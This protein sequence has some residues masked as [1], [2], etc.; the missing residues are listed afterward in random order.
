MNKENKERLFRDFPRLFRAP[1]CSEDISIV[2]DW[3]FECGDGWYELIYQLCSDIEDAAADAGV[4]KESTEWPRTMKVKEKFGALTFYLSTTESARNSIR[5]L[6][7][8]ASEKSLITCERCGAP[9][10]LHQGDYW[11][12]ACEAHK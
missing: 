10:V 4:D 8:A 6:I 11:H 9:G 7:T 5:A 2:R 1:D 3:G 12:T